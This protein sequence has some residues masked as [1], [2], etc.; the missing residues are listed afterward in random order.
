[1]LIGENIIRNRVR[2]NQVIQHVAPCQMPVDFLAVPEIW[3]Q[4]S[5]CFDCERKQVDVFPLQ[6]VN[7][8]SELDAYIIQRKKEMLKDGG[9]ILAPTHHIQANTP[10]E[11]IVEMYQ[12]D[13][14][15]I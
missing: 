15:R 12:R 11:N 13:L 14:R 9:Y 6:Q 10:T 3:N 5:M 8:L 4:L 2:V 7:S 1:M